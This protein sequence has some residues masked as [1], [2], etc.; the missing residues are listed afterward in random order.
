MTVPASRSAAAL[1]GKAT[2]KGIMFLFMPIG[3]PVVLAAY[4]GAV[5]V[6]DP[7]LAVRSQPARSDVIV[8]LGGDG[9]AR[10]AHAAWL[11]RERYAPKILVTGDGDCASIFGDMVRDGVDPAAVTIECR[12]GNTEE[13]ALFS[14]PIV[15]AMKVRRGIIVTSWVHSRRAM[16]TFAGVIPSVEWLSL[17]TEPPA[18][19]WRIVFSRQGVQ[20]AKEYPKVL[21]YA[22]RRALGGEVVTLRSGLAPIR[23]AL[24]APPR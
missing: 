8:V 15:A 7:L 9:P 6:S 21:G 11:Y 22:L 19:L 16:A 24:E 13:N 2:R 20:I 14:S 12:S 5:A 10:A 1:H 17:P 4:V 23:H 18:S 3:A